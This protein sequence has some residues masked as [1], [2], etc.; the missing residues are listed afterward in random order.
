MDS[1]AL[2]SNQTYK[3]ADLG[4]KEPKELQDVV[5]KTAPGDVFKAMRLDPLLEYKAS[6]EYLLMVE[7]KV[8]LH[9]CNAHWK[10]Y[11]STFDR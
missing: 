3:P 9:V 8:T 2:H 11:E 6:K 10:Y 5:K 1:H 4:H 7:Y